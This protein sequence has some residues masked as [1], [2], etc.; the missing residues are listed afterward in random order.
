M[1]HAAEQITARLGYAADPAIEILLPKEMLAQ[2][3]IRK[4]DMAIKELQSNMD[5]L[6]MQ[7]EMLAKEYKIR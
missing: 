2:I 6:T 1:A 3:K 4:I 7:R 5:V